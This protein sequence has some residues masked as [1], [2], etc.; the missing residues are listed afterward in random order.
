MGVFPV[1]ASSTPEP[2]TANS[3][4]LEY[5]VYLLTPGELKVATL[6]A[7]TID[8]IP[9]QGLRLG[10]SFDDG[11]VQVVSAIGLAPDGGYSEQDWEQSV[12][13]NIRTAESKHFV[14]EAGYHTLK[15]WMVDPIVVLQK[16]SSTPVE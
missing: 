12:I 16:S 6:I 7:P 10:V 5:E 2:T 4:C 9:G 8:F 13:L 14:P 3:P 1:T 11:P 15:I